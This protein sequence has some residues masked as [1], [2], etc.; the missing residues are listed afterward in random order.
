MQLRN[1]ERLLAE[2]R[3]ANQSLTD[4]LESLSRSLRGGGGGGQGCC[5]STSSS[6][7]HPQ[8]PPPPSQNNNNSQNEMSLLGELEQ[9]SADSDY[10]TM[11]TTSRNSSFLGGRNSSCRRCA[12]AK[13]GWVAAE[14]WAQTRDFLMMSNFRLCSQIEEMPEEDE[15]DIEADFDDS[16]LTTAAVDP[17]EVKEVGPKMFHA[18]PA[19]PLP[20]TTNF[21]LPKQIREEVKSAYQQLKSLCLDLKNR[22]REKDLDRQQR[23]HGQKRRR[24]SSGSSTATSAS[25]SG[26]GTQSRDDPHHQIVMVHG[27]SVLMNQ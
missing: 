14:S 3:E 5:L 9:L 18:T 23:Q 15:E 8:A 2:L 20:A 12:C 16:E 24:H 26:R 6:G 4:R 10:G 19:R 22:E 13:N 11:A 21:L 7:H 17:S 27:I 1:N 25:S